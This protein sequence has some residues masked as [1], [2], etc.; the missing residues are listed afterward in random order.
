MSDF[1]P[2]FDI[3]H[4]EAFHKLKA[5]KPYQHWSAFDVKLDEARI[6]K[7]KLFVTTIW[8]FHRTSY[9]KGRRRPTDQPAI[10]RDKTDGTLWY[11]VAKP[12][13]GTTRKNWVA[14]WNRLQLAVK[15][16]IRMVGV[17]KDVHSERCSLE[18]VF[19][20][21]PHLSEAD[22]SAIWLQ[23]KPRGQVGCKVRPVDIRQRTAQGRQVGGTDLVRTMTAGPKPRPSHKELM[24]AGQL[25]EERRVLTRKEQTFLR[26]YLFRGDHHGVCFLCGAELPIELLVAA[27][28]KPRARCSDKERR[29]LENIV[30]MC[31]LGCDALFERRYTAVRDGRVEVRLHDHIGNSKLARV[32]RG[33]QGR[34]IAVQEAKRRKYFEWHAGQNQQ[35]GSS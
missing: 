1:L 30:P 29:D 20:C 32:V 18:H 10:A 6:G 21:G 3:S 16:K 2:I 4:N 23:L 31:L 11:K 17:L 24:V 5:L 33:L 14:H 26:K 13:E 35:L 9:G 25:D 8:N 12:P 28:I 34:R 27:H 15:N 19:D 7:A 22:G